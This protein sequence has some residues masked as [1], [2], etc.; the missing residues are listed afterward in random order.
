MAS[1]MSRLRRWAAPDAEVEASELRTTAAS[2]G[3]TQ[4]GRCHA[5]EQASVLGIVRSIT[6]EPSSGLP[7][8]EAVLSDGT[9]TM[10]L[11]WLGRRRIRGIEPGRRL[12]VTGRVNA[13]GEELILYNPRYALLPGS[14]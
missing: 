11:V 9:G 7:R 14:P 1:L 8:L 2:Q 12:R 6:V 10:R 13:T 5:G 4:M 3:C